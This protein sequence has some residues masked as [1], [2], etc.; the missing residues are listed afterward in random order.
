MVDGVLVLDP[1]SDP[2]SISSS[3]SPSPLPACLLSIRTLCTRPASIHRLFRSLSSLSLCIHHRL[4]LHAAV[5]TYTQHTLLLSTPSLL[6]FLA[7]IHVFVIWL[8]VPRRPRTSTLIDHVYP[9]CLCPKRRSLPNRPT[10][11]SLPYHDPR[12]ARKFFGL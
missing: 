9:S 7:R 8:V 10:R 2:D 5:A 12:C 11:C 1:D 3:P 4:R 6:S